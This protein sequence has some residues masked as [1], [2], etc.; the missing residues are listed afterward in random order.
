M[1]IIIIIILMLS[2][3][4]KAV[5]PSPE[6][7]DNVKKTG[8]PPPISTVFTEP[9]GR[10]IVPGQIFFPGKQEKILVILVEFSDRKFTDLSPLNNSYGFSLN[11]NYFSKLIFGKEYNSSGK[12]VPYTAKYNSVNRYIK[13]ISYNQ[14]KLTGN[15]FRTTLTKKYKFYAEDSSI[16]VDNKNVPLSQILVHAVESLEKQ[17]IDLSSFDYDQDGYLDHVIIITALFNQSTVPQ[18]KENRVNCFWPKRVLFT[19]RAKKLACQKKVA[20]GIIATFDSPI[21]VLAHEFMHELGASD[22]YDPDRGHAFRKDSNDYPVSFWG[23]MDMGA[24]NY[25]PGEL[26]GECPSHALGFWRWKLGW[27]EPKII[28]QSGKITIK[29]I[30]KNKTDCLFQINTGKQDYYL[31]E[32]RNPFIQKTYYDKFFLGDHFPMDS[33]LLISHIDESVQFNQQG[34]F[35]PANWGSPEYPH[36][37]IEIIDTR[38]FFN[39]KYDERKIDAAFSEE[40]FQTELNPYSFYANL[41]SYYLKEL[42]IALSSISRSGK[43]M[44]VDISLDISNKAYIG[45]K[46]FSSYLTNQILKISFKASRALKKGKILLLTLSG[47][48]LWSQKIDIK[49]GRNKK[50][51]KIPK[52]IKNGTYSIQIIGSAH[53]QKIKS[54]KAKLIII[55]K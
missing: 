49:K 54:N 23:I 4:L 34:R 37:S 43:S 31:I 9:S 5:P 7:I 47:K 38:P 35:Y 1:L 20:W 3:F 27:I 52:T 45:L 24:W 40:D 53:K 18:T 29:A 51:I 36:Y 41:F 50:K 46:E 8:W 30:E 25:K 15:I 33:G 13:E 11:K 17:N 2:G 55:R 12:I 28:S 48:K 42:N 44:T 14:C 19:Q 10:D 39:N 6:I 26:P 32:N 22:L 21:G 16:E